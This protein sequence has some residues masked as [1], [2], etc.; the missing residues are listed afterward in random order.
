LPATFSV[1]AL[2]RRWPG[3]ALK[4]ALRQKIQ[5]IAAT[6][7]LCK[8]KGRGMGSRRRGKGPAFAAAA[9]VE[10]ALLITF[11]DILA[12]IAVATGGD[13]PP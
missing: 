5:A 12:L 9:V 1:H 3:H 10:L 8:E 6:R 4:S 13:L 7:H 11:D 2:P